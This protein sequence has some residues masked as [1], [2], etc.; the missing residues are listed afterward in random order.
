M[1]R[2]LSFCCGKSTSKP[3]SE[4]PSLPFQRLLTQ[5][6]MRVFAGPFISPDVGVHAL[7]S[8]APQSFDCLR[9]YSRRHPD[10][11]RT[12]DLIASVRQQACNIYLHR[13]SAIGVGTAS[14]DLIETFK[15]TLESFPEGS[16]GEHVL[17]WASFIAASESCRPDHQRFFVQFLE[18][19][20]RRNRFANILQALK[21]LQ[22]IWARNIHE[23]WPALL[24]EPGV[25]IN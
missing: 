18:R 7:L 15:M 6:R 3:L 21:L 11:S 5:L 16:P 25:F 20:Y 2:L 14:E 12:L 1:V 8:Q 19:H 24:P 10:H 9:Y 4:G 22:R 17:V 23:S 13:V